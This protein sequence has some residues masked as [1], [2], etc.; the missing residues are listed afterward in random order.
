MIQPYTEIQY[1]KCSRAWMFLFLNVVFNGKQTKG[2]H[3]QSKGLP[4]KIL[5]FYVFPGLLEGSTFLRLKLLVEL[6]K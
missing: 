6:E 4:M 1:C 2:R 3:V 5:F